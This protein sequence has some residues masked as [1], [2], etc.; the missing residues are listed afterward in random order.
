MKVDRDVILIYMPRG[1]SAGMIQAWYQGDHSWV[2]F[3]GP[4]FAD[5][6]PTMQPSAFQ[7]AHDSLLGMHCTVLHQ[8]SVLALM[9]NKHSDFDAF[10]RLMAA[11]V[12][13]YEPPEDAIYT[14]L[15]K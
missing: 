5:W 9:R 15:A 12:P 1:G 8:D 6:D 13:C 14:D 3:R 2:E 11:E 4:A 10:E 7:I